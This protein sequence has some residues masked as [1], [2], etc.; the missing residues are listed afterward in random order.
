MNVV[1]EMEGPV[2]GSAADVAGPGPGSAA[3]AVAQE[4]PETAAVVEIAAESERAIALTDAVEATICDA[5]EAG[6]R[7]DG[8]AVR[9][10]R[11]R[12]L[13]AL[14]ALRAAWR[15]Q[16]DANEVLQGVAAAER[17]RMDEA[18]LTG[19]RIGGTRV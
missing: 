3:D 11:T 16:A 12:G 19:V 13:V 10:A 18:R 15:D 1:G 9:A 7:G 4:G 2:P 14:A 5:L 8:A 17:D 6:Q